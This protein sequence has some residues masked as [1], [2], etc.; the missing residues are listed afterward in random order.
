MQDAVPHDRTPDARRT[1][2]PRRRP[3]RDLTVQA[4]VRAFEVLDAFRGAPSLQQAR[5][6]PRT[7]RAGSQAAQLKEATVSRKRAEWCPL[8]AKLR[9]AAT[10]PGPSPLPVRSGRSPKPT[11]SAS[12]PAYSPPPTLPSG[13]KQQKPTR[14]PESRTA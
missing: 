14:S 5:P 2:G 4:I 7:A 13:P 1:A 9:M 12:S 3:A 11:S 6:P 8:A 10:N